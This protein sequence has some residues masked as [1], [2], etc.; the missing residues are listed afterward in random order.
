MT[1]QPTEIIDRVS[2]YYKPE[3]ERLYTR[4]RLTEVRKVRQIS[5]FFLRDYTD[6]TWQQISNYFNR[7]HATAMHAY[8]AVANEF[9]TNARYRKEINEIRAAILWRLDINTDVPLHYT[10]MEKFGKQLIPWKK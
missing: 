10:L 8:K 1:I 6:L 2:E 9:E 4:S 5:M 7:D 3:L